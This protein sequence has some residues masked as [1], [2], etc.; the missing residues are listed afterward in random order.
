M[1]LQRDRRGSVIVETALITPVL[2]IMSIG[3]YDVSRMIARKTELQEVAAEVAAIAMA[4]TNANRS[5]TSLKDIAVAA[6][7]VPASAVTVTEYLKCGVNT[8]LV[9]IT[10]PCATTVESAQYVVITINASYTPYST[11][12]GVGSAVALNITRSVQVST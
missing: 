8:A 4:Q 11:N 10:A 1:R 12:F 9:A 2:L 7:G 5:T 6:A 3:A